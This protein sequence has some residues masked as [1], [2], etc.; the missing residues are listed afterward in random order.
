MLGT[1]L[2]RDAVSAGLQLECYPSKQKYRGL[3][4][5]DRGSSTVVPLQGIET[6]NIDFIAR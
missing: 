5:N 6:P 2:K 3:N 1:L 4:R